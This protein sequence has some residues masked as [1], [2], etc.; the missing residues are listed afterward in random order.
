[1]K[2]TTLPSSQQLK[3]KAPLFG[4]SVI[5]YDANV[6]GETHRQIHMHMPT[7]TLIVTYASTRQYQ[8]MIP[9]R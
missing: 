3:A 6:N 7:Q 4:P 8:N 9:H 5:V 1:M 2:V